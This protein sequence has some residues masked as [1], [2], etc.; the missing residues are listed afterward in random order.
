M[1]EEASEFF[2]EIRLAVT[3]RLTSPLVGT[4]WISWLIWNFKF[5]LIVF[6]GLEIIQKLQLIHDEMFWNGWG[7]LWT[8]GGPTAM[9]FLFIFVYPFPAQVVYEFRL[10]FQ[11]RLR[12]VRQRVEDETLLSAEDARALRLK[13]REHERN[14]SNQLAAAEQ[15]IE[16]LRKENLSIKELNNASGK[17][18]SSV[19]EALANEDIY[20][21]VA[22]D[23]LSAL[24]TL[25]I[26]KIAS[27]NPRTVS[28]ARIIGAV[29]GIAKKIGKTQTRLETL[30]ALDSLVMQRKFLKTAA[31]FDGDKYYS[32]TPSGEKFALDNNFF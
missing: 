19:Y 17:Q 16:D 7:Y 12:L 30:D 22:V 4:Y 23:P 8:Y 26:N 14:F 32:L 28:E 29:Q 21:Q 15:E 6:S 9:T 20:G 1:V 3:E 27:S 10:K 24:E 5:V 31:G 18:S 25:I 13:M 2:K 11:R